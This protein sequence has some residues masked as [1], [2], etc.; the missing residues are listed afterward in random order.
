MRCMICDY[1]E[2]GLPSEYNDG[3]EDRRS[4]RR[5]KHNPVTGEDL[6]THCVTEIRELKEDWPDEEEE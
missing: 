2:T 4:R 5:V 6:C 1:D 3:I